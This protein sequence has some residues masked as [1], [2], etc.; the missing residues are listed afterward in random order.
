MV[1]IQQPALVGEML[2]GVVLGPT[3][4]NIIEPNPA[5]S[6]ISEL[7]VFFVILTAG[8]EMNF[9]EVMSAF[10]G[11]GLL[12]SSL[13]FIIPLI[14]GVAVGAAFNLDAMR[15]IFLGLSLSI[16]ALPVAVRI[17]GE[18]KLL[19]TDIARYSIA[20]S[21]FSDL[22]ALLAL[23]VILDLPNM[24]SYEA[25]ALS[26]F[27]I[28]GKL[29]V[30]AAIVLGFNWIL[31]QVERRGL[32]IEQGPERLFQTI[33]SDALLGIVVVFVLAFSSIS[34]SLGFHYVVGAFFGALLIDKKFFLASHY[35]ETERAISGI[36]DGFLAP[37][38][39]AYLGIQMNLKELDSFGLF[40][41]VIFVAIASKVISGWIGGR[42]IGL[43]NAT[44]VGIGTILNGRGVMGLVIASIAY[45][46][47]LI[48]PQLFSILVVMSL[49]TTI[50]APMAFRK[51]VLPYLDKSE[52][53]A[54]SAQG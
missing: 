45:E 4:L 20:S 22:A 36:S 35:T 33:G 40:A 53:G 30:L 9:G 28:G 13:S 29:A 32:H 47:E 50:L 26:I 54:G 25:V 14:S 3:L 1:R 18:L 16:T 48:G 23:G 12:I 11:R 43:S 34:E 6:A 7:A 46:R 41:A 21:I 42:L 15:S 10:R 44:S 8:L 49:L 19:G 24:R 39:F 51:W 52:L 2:A 31:H 27:Q 38:F 37:I 5:L 17:L